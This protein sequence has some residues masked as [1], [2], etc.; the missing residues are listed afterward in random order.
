MSYLV[1]TALNALRDPT[2]SMLWD[3]IEDFYRG[4]YAERPPRSVRK[5]I[6]DEPWEQ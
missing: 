4:G 2:R 5:T 6:L 1:I 3:R